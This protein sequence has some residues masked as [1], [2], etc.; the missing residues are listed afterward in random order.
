MSGSR[1]LLV[2][3]LSAFVA[4][5]PTTALG[6]PP[7]PPEDREIKAKDW[8][9]GAMV[10]LAYGLNFNFPENHRFRSKTTTPRTNELA[11]NMLLAYLRKEPL[12]ESRWGT[13]LAVQGGY[14]TE[15]LVPEPQE[16]RDQ[17]MAGADILRHVSRANLSYLAPIGNGLTLSAGLMQGYINYESFYA[18]NNFNY[19][20]AYVTENSPNFMMGAG[21][22]YPLT[23]NVDV[24]FHIFN[25][26]EHLA[27]SNDLPSY[28][29]EVDWRLTKRTT[30]AQNLYFGP[31]QEAT[32]LRFWRFFADSQLEWRG[33]NLTL[34]AI[35]DIGT[36]QAADLPGSPRTFWTGAALFSRW[37]LQGPWSAAV[38]PEFYWDRNGRMT[39]SEQFIWAMTT[40]IEYRRH[41]GP[42]LGVVRL[43]H[44]YDDSTGKEGGFFRRGD[45]SPGVPALSRSQHVI[46]L[47]LL[48]AFD[49]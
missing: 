42:Q 6:Q 40:T 31:D 18:K 34:A 4:I 33:E 41:F 26:Y 2:V 48:W 44:R 1:G 39:D 30:F 37:T 3:A 8:Q 20:R 24:G 38:R 16:G 12:H 49:S 11:P 36:E 25:G 45:I 14:D 29:A 13:E 19:T 28:G 15:A 9:L 5:L 43:E 27:H 22:R 7:V 17:P 47:S 21:A 46:F 10:D 35:Y 32:S 23:G